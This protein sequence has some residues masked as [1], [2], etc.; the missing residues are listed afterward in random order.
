MNTQKEMI[1]KELVRRGRAGLPGLT[2]LEA[3][4]QLGVGRL[5]SRIFELKMDGYE[6]ERKMV[7]VVKANG[8]TADVAAYSVDPKYVCSEREA[9]AGT[10]IRAVQLSDLTVMVEEDAGEEGWREVPG[11][12]KTEDWALTYG[13][14]LTLARTYKKT[15]E[16]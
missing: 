10:F 12:R 9:Y 11:T 4:T 1:A 16:G 7:S 14:L 13:E 5:A 8:E 15:K 3:L 2:Q 6:I